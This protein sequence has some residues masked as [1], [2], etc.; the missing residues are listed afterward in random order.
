M[1]RAPLCR[2]WCTRKEKIN[3][4][5][6]DIKLPF[7]RSHNE[8]I[9]HYICP[10]ERRARSSKTPINPL[11]NENWTRSSKFR[12]F[13]GDGV[14]LSV[15]G[16]CGHWV[17]KRGWGRI[18]STAKRRRRALENKR[19]RSLRKRIFPGPSRSGPVTL[20]F[21]FY[22]GTSALCFSNKQNDLPYVE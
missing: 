13:T 15:Q 7:L 21:C 9:F 16:L 22:T 10:L 2:E 1:S 12:E 14:W 11:S 4:L 18:L 20:S 5:K 3:V 17:G 8:F 6:I 19:T